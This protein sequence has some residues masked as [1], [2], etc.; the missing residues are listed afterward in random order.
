MIYIIRKMY[1]ACGDFINFDCSIR[2]I[3]KIFNNV[4]INNNYPDTNDTLLSLELAGSIHK[5]VRKHLQPYLKPNIKLVDIAEII[6]KKTMELSNQQKSINKGIGFPVGLSINNC[7]AHYHPKTNEQTKLTSDDIIKI[8]FGTEVNGWIIDSAFTVCFNSKFNN[9]LD[10]VKDGTET[11]IKNLGVDA[12]IADYGSSIQEVIESY[13]IILDKKIC[14]IKAIQ[15]LGG[16]N[17]TKGIIHGGMF[18]P[19]VKSNTKERFKA[20][21][22]A[23]ETFGSTGDNI[24]FP[25]GD[26]TLFRLNPKYTNNVL[27]EKFSTLPF[28]ERYIYDINTA[29]LISNNIIYAYPPLYVNSGYTAQ[30][31]HTIYLDEYKKIVISRGDDY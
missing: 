14:P 26:P 9:L 30:Y 7:V 25:S 6:E 17:I 16:H 24:S 10:A 12:S 20:G 21:V 19:C 23:V 22:Y 27:Y 11:G 8:D 28:C 13:E 1:K 2:G 5:E 29:N 4:E 18:L 3:N 31:E 15:N